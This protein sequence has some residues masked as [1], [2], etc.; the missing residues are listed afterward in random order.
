MSLY[1]LFVLLGQLE[2]LYTFLY[3]YWIWRVFCFINFFPAAEFSSTS[4]P[5]SLWKEHNFHFFPF[6]IFL[7]YYHS[8]FC[9]CFLAFFLRRYY[10]NYIFIC[11]QMFS[12]FF[13]F[14]LGYL[15]FRSLWLSRVSFT[16]SEGVSHLPPPIFPIRTAWWIVIFVSEVAVAWKRSSL[17]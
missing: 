17:L 8:F 3:C 4:T 7:F 11:L 10:C 5:P 9:L 16:M 6:L 13:Y 14:V 15:K 1:C 2:V 12:L